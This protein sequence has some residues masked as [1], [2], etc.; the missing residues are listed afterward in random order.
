MTLLPVQCSRYC[1]ECISLQY[2]I[3]FPSSI[4]SDIPSTFPKFSSAPASLPPFDS[5][6]SSIPSDLP[7]AAP[8]LSSAPALLP[9]FGGIPSSVPSPD[10][11]NAPAA[12]TT[13]PRVSP[14]PGAP[15]ISGYLT[16]ADISLDIRDQATRIKD[17]ADPVP[18][19][20]YILCPDTTLTFNDGDESIAPAFDDS[21]FSCG[22][23]G[24]G[25]GCQIT[26]G[27]TQ[28]II[29]EDNLVSGSLASNLTVVFQGISYGGFSDTAFQITGTGDVV[30]VEFED[31][32]FVVSSYLQSLL[33]HSISHLSSDTFF[34][35]MQ[36]FQSTTSII[37]ISN[38][39]ESVATFADGPAV[40]MTNIVIKVRYALGILVFMD[41]KNS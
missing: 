19:Y 26:G 13:G 10:L 7:S 18:P 9:P 5:V 36:D 39:A 14:C 40:K 32:S 17:G 12:P 25:K 3:G 35:L 28:F 1:S 38:P 8:N 27:T 29:N 21:F 23:D 4:P 15:S 22:S 6:P 41:G 33:I 20:R 37:D 11:S 24:L 34:S 31:C 30:F 16:I 2:K